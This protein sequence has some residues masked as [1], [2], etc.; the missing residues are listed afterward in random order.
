MAQA[1]PNDPDDTGFYFGGL[2]I[3]YQPKKKYRLDLYALG[4]WNR[5]QTMD[6]E[7]DLRRVTLGTYD[8]GKLDAIDYEVEVA[9]QLGKRHNPVSKESQ[10]VSAFMLTGSI[11]YTID[12]EYKPRIAAGYEYLSGQDAGD[13]DYK[14]FDTLFATNH[15]FYGL[16]PQYSRGYGRGRTTRSDGKVPDQSTQKAHLEGR[17]SPLHVCER[18][19]KRKYLWAGS[20]FDCHLPLR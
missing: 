7:D 11:E 8:R 19:E 3:T 12:A 10:T 5:K 15:K 16:L 9:A 13:E 18:G 2:Y 1:D 4:E 14:V 6:D 20:R 17:S